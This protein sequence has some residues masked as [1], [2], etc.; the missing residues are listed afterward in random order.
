MRHIENLG[1]GEFLQEYYVQIGT[2]DTIPNP[3]FLNYSENIVKQLT[4][5]LQNP[6]NKGILEK[7]LDKISQFVQ[8]R[9]QERISMEDYMRQQIETK[10]EEVLKN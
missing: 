6:E 2:F 4:E 5:L 7:I 10:E 9:D 1:A 3:V 8:S